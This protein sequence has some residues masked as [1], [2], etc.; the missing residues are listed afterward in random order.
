V[1]LDRA[2]YSAL[3]AALVG[4]VRPGNMAREEIA[5]GSFQQ[6]IRIIRAHEIGDAA[7]RHKEADAF[8]F[9]IDVIR[10]QSR[11]GA[12]TFVVLR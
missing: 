12:A 3:L 8:V 6:P 4:I 2:R 10:A 5:R 9:D 1:A 7:I 11:S